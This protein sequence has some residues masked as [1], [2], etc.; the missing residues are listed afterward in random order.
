MTTIVTGW[1][2]VLGASESGI[3]NYEGMC[4][5]PKL[6]DGRQVII[7]CADSQDRYMGVLH[8]WFRTIVLWFLIT[9][10]SHISRFCLYPHFSW[11]S[12]SV[13]CM[14]QGQPYGLACL[15]YQASFRWVWTILHG[16]TYSILNDINN[17]NFCCFGISV[18]HLALSVICGCDERQPP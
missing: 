15:L 4:L 16:L 18:I 9:W 3:A 1:I 6:P 8:D 11:Q 10:L 12:P 17:N 5:G 14:L 2:T 13:H 7:L